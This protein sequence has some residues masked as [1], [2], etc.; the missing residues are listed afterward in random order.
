MPTNKAESLPPKYLPQDWLEVYNPYTNAPVDLS[1]LIFSDNSGPA[2][3]RPVPPLSFMNSDDYVRFWADDLLGGTEANHLN[4]K[5]GSKN[6]DVLTLWS[7]G[8]TSIIDRVT[9]T[10]CFACGDYSFGRLPDGSTNL[11][12]F[13]PGRS[14]PGDSNFLPLSF[15]CNV[16]INEVLA[17]TDPPLMD[18]LELYN[19]NETNL[20]LDNFWLSNNEFNPKKFR[21]PTN[22][23]IQPHGFLVLYEFQFNRTWTGNDPDFTFN[24]AHGDQVAIYSA[25]SDAGGTLTGYRLVK[26]FGSSANGVSFGRYVKSDGGTDFVPMSSLTFGLDHFPATTNEFTL[27]RGASNSYP[28][29]GPIVI[30]EIMYHPPDVIEITNA[31]DTNG[32][33]VVV[34]NKIDNDW[35]EFV[36]LSNYAATNAPLYNVQEPTN[37]WTLV[38]G[39]DYEFPTGAYIRSNGC[40][41]VVNFNPWTNLTQLAL[42]RDKYHVPDSFTNFF[43]PYKG[44]LANNSM[45]LQLYKPDPAQQPPHPDAG[46]VPQVFVEKVKY[47]DQAPWPTNGV[48]GGGLSLHRLVLSGYANDQTNWFGGS[49]TPGRFDLPTAPTLVA[50][51]RQTDG[52][53]LVTV[54]TT[55]GLNYII[56]GTVN[57]AP[58]INWTPLAT[59]TNVGSQVIYND[60]GTNGFKYFR[61]LISP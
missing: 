54:V 40:A 10:A 16:V 61:A 38:D 14:T 41:L 42:F 11:A 3:K 31:L 60:P 50:P 13:P 4:M 34:T 7:V 47:E 32:V 21:F 5:I 30:S 20:V 2:G 51:I 26:T 39:V 53:I 22:V 55:P 17:H 37:H 15:V 27:G 43:G 18:A 28:K 9:V 49:P 46:Y 57:L 48:D 19:P 12:T 59:F 24:S 52:T 23:V 6:G 33:M 44:K 56:E 1:G 58:T 29:V 35:D 25:A 45:T 8:A 36:E